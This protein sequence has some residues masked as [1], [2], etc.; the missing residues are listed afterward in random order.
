MPVSPLKKNLANVPRKPKCSATMTVTP[1]QPEPSGPQHNPAPDSA[2]TEG[3]DD[4]AEEIICDPPPTQAQ[5]P[6][7]P[8]PYDLQ[9]TPPP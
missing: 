2:Y 4:G 8:E 1:P 6:L 9:D 7:K 5:T 3:D